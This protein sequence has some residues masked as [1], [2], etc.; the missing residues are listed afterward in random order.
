MNGGLE[1]ALF[2]IK[3]FKEG[4]ISNSKLNKRRQPVRFYYLKMCVIH[5]SLK[6]SFE[7][8]PFLFLVGWTS[9]P[10]GY[11]FAS[12]ICFIYFMISQRSWSKLY[13]I[14]VHISLP[15]DLTSEFISFNLILIHNRIRVCLSETGEKEERWRETV[16]C[17]NLAM[18]RVGHGVH[19]VTSSQWLVY[20]QL[21]V[22]FFSLAFL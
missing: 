3:C 1:K 8:V 11:V 16:C 13:S 10:N 4:W 20:V 6:P 18:A 21:V 17:G 14:T 22:K 2:Q 12:G 7:K 15:V 9:H 19:F 5:P